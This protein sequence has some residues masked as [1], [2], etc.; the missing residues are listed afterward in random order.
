[1]NSACSFRHSALSS[2]LVFD[3]ARIGNGEDIT[4]ALLSLGD[5]GGSRLLSLIGNGEDIAIA[6]LSLGD[7]GGSRLGSFPGKEDA[8]R[9]VSCQGNGDNG[10]VIAPLG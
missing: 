2:A 5:P 10:G 8:P 1:M 7:P 4:I 6:F 3:F 9:L